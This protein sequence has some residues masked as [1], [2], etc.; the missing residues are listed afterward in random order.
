MAACGRSARGQ[1]DA[2]RSPRPS[3]ARGS[4]SRSSCS[5]AWGI[6]GWQNHFILEV[7]NEPL[8]DLDQELFGAGAPISFGVPSSSTTLMAYGGAAPVAAVHPLPALRLRP[9][10][11]QPDRAQGG[12]AAAPDGP[13]ALHLRRA[14]LLLRRPRAGHRVPARLQR[15]RVHDRGAGARLLR[16]FAL[17]TI[18]VG[19]LFQVPVVILALTRPGSRPGAAQAPPFRDPRLRCPGAL[20]PTIDPLTMILEMIPLIVLYE[21]TIMLAPGSG[22][23]RRPWRPEPE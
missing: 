1:A 15:R 20:L 18:A 12:H 13:G 5:A 16:F 8:E 3:C 4:S 23:R 10:G 7:V 14:V 2:R 21:L 22:G 19:I 11:V 17:T 9:A 6:C